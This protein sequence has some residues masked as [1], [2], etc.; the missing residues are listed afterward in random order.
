MK[1]RLLCIGVAG[2]VFVLLALLW[3]SNYSASLVPRYV[4]TVPLNGC[5]DISFDSQGIA[6]GRAV[7]SRVPPF[8]AS[9]FVVFAVKEQ[10]AIR[11]RPKNFHGIYGDIL[12][13]P[14]DRGIVYVYICDNRYFQMLV[15]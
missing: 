15:N 13:E 7:E 14:G 11:F 3:L 6:F 8:D 2:I 1:V 4:T 5:S 9:R 10:K 12:L